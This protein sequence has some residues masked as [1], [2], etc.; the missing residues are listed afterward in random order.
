M[1]TYSV[2]VTRTLETT[3][4]VEAENRFDAIEQVKDIYKT[5]EP[6]LSPDDWTT[7]CFSAK[8]PLV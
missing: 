8:G 3:V 7:T 4:E 5:E 6:T 1:A 2:T